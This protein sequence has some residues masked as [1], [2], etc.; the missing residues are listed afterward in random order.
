[1]KIGRVLCTIWQKTFWLIF[2]GTQ[3]IFSECCLCIVQLLLEFEG[4]AQECEG[5]SAVLSQRLKS[6]ASELQTL[7]EKQLQVGRS[8]LVF[9]WEQLSASGHFWLWSNEFGTKNDYHPIL[10]RAPQD[11]SVLASFASLSWLY[12]SHLFL[13]DLVLSC[14]LEM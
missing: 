12:L 11:I 7:V 2:S 10:P 4:L 6:V 1:M 13:V 3:C 8:F 9:L 5:D 14:T